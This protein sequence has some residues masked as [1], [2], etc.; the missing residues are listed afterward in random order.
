M[1]EKQVAAIMDVM[2]PGNDP[3]PASLGADEQALFGL[4]YYHQRNEFFK[5]T[6]DAVVSGE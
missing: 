2:E 3:F 1:L 6:D 4:G 5:K